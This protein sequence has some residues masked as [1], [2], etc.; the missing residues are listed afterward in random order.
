MWL[1]FIHC[2]S[3]TLRM[4]PCTSSNIL[5]N[6]L[7]F[8]SCI[9]KSF[10]PLIFLQIFPASSCLQFYQELFLL[11]QI[12]SQSSVYFQSLTVTREGKKKQIQKQTAPFSSDS[13]QLPLLW[14]PVSARILMPLSCSWD[15]S[16]SYIWKIRSI[17][18]NNLNHCCLQPKSDLPGS[19]CANKIWWLIY[20]LT[21][22]DTTTTLATSVFNYST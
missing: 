7:Y 13:N 6:F 21:P 16:V 22:M 3:V 4:V 19:F 12:I 2:N 15:L 17:F 14:Y 1:S 18:K 8:D 11:F 9:L 5:N 10:G 20:L